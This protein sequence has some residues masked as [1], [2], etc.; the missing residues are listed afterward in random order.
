MEQQE[1]YDRKPWLITSLV[2][3]LQLLELIAQREDGCTAKWLSHMSGIKLSTC[4]HLLNSLIY[5]GY[6]RKDK[7]TQEYC[8]SDKVAHLNNLYQRQRHIPQSIKMLAQSLMHSTGE[9]VYVAMWEYGEIPISYI[10]ESTQNVKVRSLYVG[11]KD[12]A[13]VRALGK[14]V[15]AHISPQELM[16]YYRRHLPSMCTIHSRISWDAIQEILQQVREKGFALDR[17]EFEPGVCCIGVPVYQLDGAVWGAI[18]ISMP[19]S[20]FDPKDSALI[21]FVKG[22]ALAAS[23][24]LGYAK[25]Q[26]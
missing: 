9:T 16:T 2:R 19:A 5:T 23:L 18:S 7:H 20:R 11:Y 6:V 17:E 14:A 13:F 3:G 22:Q 21:A 25:E 12:H 26:S 1:E 8:L 10:A 4:Y 15:L 24:H